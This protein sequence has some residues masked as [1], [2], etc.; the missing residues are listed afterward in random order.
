MAWRAQKNSKTLEGADEVLR[1]GETVVLGERILRRV[2]LWAEETERKRAEKEAQ[3]RKHKEVEEAAQR[4]RE[5]QAR[6]REEEERA[7]REAEEVQRVQRG[8][9]A[10]A[11]DEREEGEVAEGVQGGTDV[12]MGEPAGGE[13]VPVAKVSFKFLLINSAVLMLVYPGDSSGGE[14]GGG[15]HRPPYLGAAALRA[16]QERRMRVR[17]RSGAVVPGLHDRQ[18][19][20]H[21]GGRSGVGAG[22]ACEAGCR[23]REARDCGGEAEAQAADQGAGGVQ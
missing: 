21:P 19:E 2:Q 6:A 14:G 20:V 11:E 8:N 15:A 5:V 9:A 13:G 17:R 12:E 23:Q 18:E 4:E 1:L 3:E 7:R 10:M 22:A 16:V